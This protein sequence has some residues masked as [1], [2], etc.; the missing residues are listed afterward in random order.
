MDE[1][2]REAFEKV[3]KDI[4]FLTEQIVILRRELEEI[5]R[6]KTNFSEQSSTGNEGVP[7]NKQTN[8]PTY[9][10]LSKIV[11]EELS[12]FSKPVW[13]NPTQTPTDVQQTNTKPQQTNTFSNTSTD[14]EN[15]ITSM[16]NTLKNDLKLRFRS[17]TKQEFHLFSVLFTVDKTQ[18]HATYKDIADKTGLS[19]AS[20][21]DYMQ[22]ISKKGIP[23]IKEKL[24]NKLI[25]LK[26]PEELRNLATL[27]NLLRIRNQ[28]PDTSLDKFNS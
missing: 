17:L 1:K 22:R 19:E 16:V 25:I 14:A 24:N 23:I 27:D 12:M 28:M 21:R 6:I 7:T 9:N 15:S 20:V 26:I 5:K 3:K 2:V 13:Q 10:T 4:D 18:K 8:T 11:D